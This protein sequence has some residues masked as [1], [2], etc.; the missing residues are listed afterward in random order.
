MPH[1]CARRLSHAN[2]KVTLCIPLCVASRCV[3]EKVKRM[4]LLRFHFSFFST[5]AHDSTVNLPLDSQRLRLALAESAPQYFPHLINSTVYS[6]SLLTP[7]AFTRLTLR[8]RR[9]ARCICC[10]SLTRRHFSWPRSSVTRNSPS[11]DNCCLPSRIQLTPTSHHHGT[12]PTSSKEL[13]GWPRST[14]SGKSDE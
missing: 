12:T 9:R 10:P 2:V 8:H 13:S 11:M 14:L 3:S 6:L 5:N 1:H 4:S 7:D